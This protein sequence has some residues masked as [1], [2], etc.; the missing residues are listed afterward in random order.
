[1]SAI[2]AYESGK[3]IL[4]TIREFLPKLAAF[5]PGIGAAPQ[6]QSEIDIESLKDAK[7]H[8]SKVTDPAQRSLLIQAARLECDRI[9]DV[10]F[11]PE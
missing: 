3:G 7:T 9:R 4:P 1:V 6:T 5:V 10:E 2:L 8:L 11:K